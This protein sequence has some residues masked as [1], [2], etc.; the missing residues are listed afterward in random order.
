MGVCATLGWRLRRSHVQIKFVSSQSIQ[1]NSTEDKSAQAP[2]H[3]QA[4]NR[5]SQHISTEFVPSSQKLQSSS[6]SSPRPYTQEVSAAA[7]WWTMSMRQHDLSQQE[8]AAFEQALRGGMEAR[9]EGHWYPSEPRRGS[10]YRSVIKDLTT[11]Q[12]L[13]SAGLSARIRDVASRLP[14]AV[15]WINPGSVRV[16]VEGERLSQDLF[17]LAV[18]PS[19]RI[20]KGESIPELNGSDEDST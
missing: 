11:D 19:Y 9:C 7:K 2:L 14:C 10:G 15:V 17:P 13:L 1:A 16:Q 18:A 6:L 3:I 8:V 20:G 12:L 4:S 5:F